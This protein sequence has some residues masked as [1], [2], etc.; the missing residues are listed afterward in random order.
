MGL[1]AR[2]RDE[3][4]LDFG[5]NQEDN[6]LSLRSRMSEPEPYKREML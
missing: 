6:N 2:E 4:W 1:G 5:D 3:N